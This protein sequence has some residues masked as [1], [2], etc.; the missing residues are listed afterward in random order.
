MRN[1]ARQHVEVALIVGEEHVARHARGVRE[2][3]RVRA[4]LLAQRVDF[5]LSHQRDR[6]GK[7][8]RT[9]EERP[10]EDQHAI[11]PGAQGEVTGQHLA[12]ARAHEPDV[13]APHT[14]ID[15]SFAAD[16]TLEEIIE[17]ALQLGRDL[18]HRRRVFFQSELP[19]A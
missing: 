13:A 11:G 1:E 9:F 19:L 14:P 15:L 18:D 7:I 2:R 12:L 4:L 6:R 17:N 10:P 5:G 3:H 8:R 16:R